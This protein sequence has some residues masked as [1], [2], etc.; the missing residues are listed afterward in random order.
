VALLAGVASAVAAFDFPLRLL[1][2]A[3]VS[4][5]ADLSAAAGVEDASAVAAFDFLL[6]LLVEVVVS[7]AADLSLAA[8]V[9]DASAV[10][11]FDF[12]L[13]FVVV[14]AVV[15]PAADLSLAA[16]ASFFA[17]FL[18]FLVVVSELVSVEL[19]ELACAF[20]KAGE[21]ATVSIKQKASIHRVSLIWECFIFSSH[22]LRGMKPH[23]FG[24]KY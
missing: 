11:A 10:A 18:D 13:F 20:A 6:R 15:S 9:E 16:A 8:G 5:V 24:K 7:V 12:L 21:M 2:E 3:V 17:F 22:D 1:V 4:A 19:V 14:E 23:I